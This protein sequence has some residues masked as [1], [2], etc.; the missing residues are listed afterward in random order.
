MTGESTRY[1]KHVG[2]HHNALVLY[3]CMSNAGIQFSV[4]SFIVFYLY[5][6]LVMHM[7]NGYRVSFTEGYTF[8]GCVIA[9]DKK[10]RTNI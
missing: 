6:A 2:I 9:T 10:K 4:P 3:R 5:C 8:L 1:Y 7:P